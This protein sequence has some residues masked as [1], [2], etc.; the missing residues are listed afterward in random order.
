MSLILDAL[1]KAENERR[2]E[3]S[4]PN[5]NTTHSNDS[6]QKQA[7][8]P[9]ILIGLSVIALLVVGG[10]ATLFFSDKPQHAPTSI[11]Q[12]NTAKEVKPTLKNQQ[13]P[14][15][16]KTQKQQALIAAQYQ[17]EKNKLLP[18]P[19]DTPPNTDTS[20]EENIQRLYEP[21]PLAKGDYE[22][23]LPTSG[24][25]YQYSI[26]ATKKA[27]QPK[28]ATKRITSTQNTS[29]QKTKTVQS[30]TTAA[31][32]STAATS[33]QPTHKPVTQ[34]NVNTANST[35]QLSLVN[36]N[37]VKL[38]KDLPFSAQENIPSMMY[39]EHHYRNGRQSS[40]VING[41]SVREG[42]NIGSGVRMKKI[43]K[44][45]V[46]LQYDRFE[47]KMQALNSWLNY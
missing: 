23:T 31:A 37:N 22:T 36:Y 41:K 7:Y 8:R 3:D 15:T 17:D 4:V 9:L 20:S 12:D 13:P 42:E 21:P 16:Q 10:V 11:A 19:T 32:R 38:I 46:L 1:K 30:S 45:G 40:V 47:F 2:G 44:D 29:A 39:T 27:E 33:Q 6:I 18:E 14:P 24:A 26:Q 35:D 34:T 43:L 28:T 25:A 5:I